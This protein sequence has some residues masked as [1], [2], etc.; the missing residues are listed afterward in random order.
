MSHFLSRAACV[1]E[2]TVFLFHDGY[3]PSTTDGLSFS[4]TCLG[5]ACQHPKG[6]GRLLH[7][8]LLTVAADAI[9]EVRW[10]MCTNP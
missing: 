6:N 4:N 5:L 3:N 10:G 9:N 2:I 1:L 8:R 7:F